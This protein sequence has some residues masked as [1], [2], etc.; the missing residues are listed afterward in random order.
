MSQT[1]YLA[2]LRSPEWK[3]KRLAALEVW[4]FSCA[5]NARHRGQ[6]EVHHRTYERLGDELHTDVVV[7]CARCHRRFHG[8]LPAV[9][10]LPF[11][12]QRPSGYDLN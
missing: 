9:T 7:L 10:L 12:A 1:E 2:Y 8:L 3:S 6:L 5:L 11:E 4:G